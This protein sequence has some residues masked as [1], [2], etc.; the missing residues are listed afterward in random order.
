VY[1]LIDAHADTVDLATD[2]RS[3]PQWAAHLDYLQALQRA[4]HEMLARPPG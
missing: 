2:L 3:Q 4:A 1:E